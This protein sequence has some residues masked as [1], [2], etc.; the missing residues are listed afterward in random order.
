D[1]GSPGRP[2]VAA[3]GPACSEL[4]GSWLGGAVGGRCKA[5]W[6][7]RC[8]G[9]AQGGRSGAGPVVA[10]HK[11]DAVIAINGQ[12]GCGID[13]EGEEA[14]EIM[15]RRQAAPVIGRQVSQSRGSVASHSGAPQSLCANRN[16]LSD[17]TPETGRSPA[18]GMAVDEVTRRR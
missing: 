11:I 9:T 14:G 18:H 6:A 15:Q 17:R 2:P 13:F 10:A 8:G 16:E 1:G 12:T 7:E 3:P 5:G 4:S